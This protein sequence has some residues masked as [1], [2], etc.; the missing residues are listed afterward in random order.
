MI[1]SPEQLVEL[2]KDHAA[3]R[4]IGKANPPLVEI[5]TRMK[6][7][8]LTYAEAERCK[9]AVIGY[10]EVLRTASRLASQ[11]FLTFLVQSEI[12]SESMEIRNSLFALLTGRDAVDATSPLGTDI[13]STL[14]RSRKSPSEA[15]IKEF[16]PSIRAIHSAQP[17][18]RFVGA[19]V[20][21]ATQSPTFS[22]ELG[23]LLDDLEKLKDEPD[24]DLAL[25]TRNAVW[26]TSKFGVDSISL[27]QHLGKRTDGKNFPSSIEVGCFLDKANRNIAPVC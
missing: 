19:L 12:G 27:R 8:Q 25:R 17:E 5:I 4:W 21:M 18:W 14:L 11:T 3:G 13:I 20:A 6:R 22:Y 23:D 7:G 9:A 2:I 26:T 24:F 1:E 15:L 10:C 16:G